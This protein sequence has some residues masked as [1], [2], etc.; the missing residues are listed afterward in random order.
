MELPKS[1]VQEAR[2]PRKSSCSASPSQEPSTS[3]NEA[4]PFTSGYV[5]VHIDRTGLEHHI[6]DET[7]QPPRKLRRI[8]RKA[9][10]VKY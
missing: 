2:S 8:Y 7:V 4:V 5:V 6:L 9:I 3:E 10:K 1:T